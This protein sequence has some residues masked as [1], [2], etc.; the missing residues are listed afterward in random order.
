[1]DDSPTECAAVR[2]QLP[3]VLVVEVPQG[4]PWMLVRRIS[5]SGAFDS[6]NIT[7]DDR[8]RT[9][10]YKAQSKRAELDRTISSR[11]E[12]LKSLHIVCTV[13]DGLGANLPRT[14]QLINKTNVGLLVSERGARVLTVRVADCFGDAGLVG[15]AIY[16]QREACAY[17]ET[18]LLS[19]RVI[20]RGIETAL[21]GCLAAEA[22]S[23]GALRLFGEYMATSKN[24]ISA[25]FY[26][27][28]GFVE[29]NQKLPDMTAGDGVLYEFDLG[30]GVPETP[31]WIAIEGDCHAASV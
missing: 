7:E 13:S 27:R 11:E 30:A 2:Q 19:C 1:V 8:R 28:H 23:R 24:Q 18:F 3:G 20:G 16:L 26:P 21:L 31:S 12:F 22:R 29:T 4:E 14:V 17:I 10:E 9:E 15:V 5:E 25:D 6:L